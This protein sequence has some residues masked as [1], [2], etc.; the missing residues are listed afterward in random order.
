MS[1]QSSL[2]AVAQVLSASHQ[3]E[4]LTSISGPQDRAKV[5]AFVSSDRGNA[6]KMGLS[7]FE[8][9]LSFHACIYHEVARYIIE[10]CGPQELNTMEKK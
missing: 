4:T 10:F 1:A 7:R 9:V 2:S 6:D 3:V 8:I 5:V